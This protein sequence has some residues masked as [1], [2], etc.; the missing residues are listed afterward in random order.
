MCDVM[1][2]GPIQLI[3]NI[4]NTQGTA[5][6]RACV[7]VRAC[8]GIRVRTCVSGWVSARALSNFGH[9]GS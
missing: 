7:R 1:L 3:C 4:K 5:D 2:S 9:C 8:D 6:V